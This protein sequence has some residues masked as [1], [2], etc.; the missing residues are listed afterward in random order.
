MDR[1]H[2]F[3]GRTRAQ[4]DARMLTYRA[5]C[6]RETRDRLLRL[7]ADVVDPDVARWES[8]WLD[9]DADGET[10]DLA[11][12]AAHEACLIRRAEWPEI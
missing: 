7:L 9:H 6:L 12:A 10:F 1:K 4:N 5:S 3:L 2:A 11:K 8:D